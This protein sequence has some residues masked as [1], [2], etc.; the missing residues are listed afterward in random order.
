MNLKNVLFF[1]K[2]IFDFSTYSWANALNG[3][4]RNLFLAKIPTYEIQNSFRNIP[5]CFPRRSD[6]QGMLVWLFIA[7]LILIVLFRFSKYK[8]KKNYL[9]WQ[10][11]TISSLKVR[12]NFFEEQKK[13]KA[14][15]IFQLKT[16]LNIFLC[17]KPKT[18]TK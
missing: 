10:A 3:L 6:C 16:K 14:R 17:L 13:N 2:F 9:S 4:K 5:L 11:R 7:F 15:P 18:T 1:W 12:T 8:H